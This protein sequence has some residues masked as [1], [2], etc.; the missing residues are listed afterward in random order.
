MLFAQ[1]VDFQT[2]VVVDLKCLNVGMHFDAA[3]TQ[4]QNV[5]H[6]PFDVGAVGM[7]GTQPRKAALPLCHGAGDELVDALHLLRGRRHRLDDTMIH[8]CGNLLV[9]QGLHRTVIHRGDTVKGIGAPHRLGGDGGR[10]LVT[11][12]VHHFILSD[13]LPSPALIHSSAS[14]LILYLRILPAAFMGNFA[15]KRMYRG[16]LCRAIWAAM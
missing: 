10:I 3:Q 1:F 13:H 4:F 6:V 5:L 9:Q 11:M 12:G 7:E 14:S 15:T 2:T 8:P 16:T